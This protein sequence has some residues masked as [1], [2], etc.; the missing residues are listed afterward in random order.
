[1]KSDSHINKYSIRLKRVL[2]KNE[3]HLFYIFLVGN[4]IPIYFTPYIG[5]LDGPKHLQIANIIK[6]LWM[7]NELFKQYFEFSAFYVGN[8]LGHYL[9][10]IFRLVFPA[11]LSEKLLLTF[12]IVSIATGF[13]YLI[14]GINVKPNYVYFFIFP[15]TYTSLFIMGF[16][17]Y[18]IAFGFLF[19]ATGYYLRHQPNLL[20]HNI[21]ILIL[22]VLLTYYSHFFV[23]IFLLTILVFLFLSHNIT[24]LS[25]VGRNY[26]PQFFRNLILSVLVVLPS[27]LLALLYLKLILKNPASDNELQFMDR[28]LHLKELKVLI[29]YVGTIELNYTSKLFW[30]LILLNIIIFIQMFLPRN[31][32]KYDHVKNIVANKD[33]YVWG[34]LVMIFFLL[35]F[36]IPNNA[37]AAGNILNRTVI[38]SLYLWVI[39]LSIKNMPAII[40]VL[41]LIYL[42]F[43]MYVMYSFHIE[44]RKNINCVIENIKAVEEFIPDNSLF[45]GKNYYNGWLY[46]HFE[47]YI[48]TDKPILNIESKAISPLFA[49]KWNTKMPQTFLGPYYSHEYTSVSN[50]PN[51]A[52]NNITN[53][54]AIVD[55]N[56]FIKNNQNNNIKELIELYYTERKDIDNCLVALYEVSILDEIEAIKS[57]ISNEAQTISRLQTKSYETGVPLNDLLM[58]EAIWYYKLNS[59]KKVDN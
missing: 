33:T 36:I 19:I 27:L 25:T 58:R 34:I 28:W 16:Y 55:K 40:N 29:G 56:E 30:I 51:V 11:W 57:E 47:A 24:N 17:N 50:I 9:L 39:W 8:V 7:G 18:S 3:E 6:E 38:F 46:Y 20:P 22:F 59:Q 35:Y 5:S 49:V 53:Y 23:Y 15:F 52:G 26:I 42:A 31:T 12:Y 54:I 10:A 14:K 37:N 43:N 32:V 4:L 21:I 41:L 45:L 44:Q 13:R 48:G 1:M 2:D